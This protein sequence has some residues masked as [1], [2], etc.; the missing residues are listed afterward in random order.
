[1]RLKY[2]AT[3]CLL[4]L[5]I[6]SANATTFNWTLSGEPSFGITGSGTLT[7]SES[8]GQY[9][10]DSIFGSVSDT[11]SGTP[12]VPRYRNIISILTPNQAYASISDIGGDNLIFPAPASTFLDSQG[13]VFSIGGIGGDP[14]PFPTGCYMNIYY[15]S[16]G[17]YDLHTSNGG[18]NGIEF[19]LTA[20]VASTPLPAAL[21]LFVSGF[22]ALG[23]IGWRRKRK[24]SAA[25]AVG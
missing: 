16:N 12:C 4:T 20:D 11:C 9:L 6:G 13:L 19:I 1:M 7:A 17:Q 5:T 10:V 23:L 14:C 18:T 25:L 22:G 3:A 15:A 24:A 2:L 21:P 8:G